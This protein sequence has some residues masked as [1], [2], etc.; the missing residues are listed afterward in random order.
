MS[1]FTLVNEDVRQE[2]RNKKQ[3]FK[4]YPNKQKTRYKEQIIKQNKAK[5]A[6]KLAKRNGQ[7]EFGREIR[8]T[9]ETNYH[10]HIK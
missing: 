2:I 10:L 3:A 5:E 1:S 6:V 8:E 7:E 4:R 9:Y